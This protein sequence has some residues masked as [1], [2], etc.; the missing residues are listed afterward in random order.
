MR[1]LVERVTQLVL[2]WP[3]LA[4]FIGYCAVTAVLGRDVL[5]HLSSTIIHDGGDPLLTAALLRWN[6]SVLPLTHAWW[7]F[8][9]FYPTPDAL[10]FSEHLLGLSVVA[11]PIEW[12]LRDPLAAANLVTLLTYPLSGLAVLLL[13]RHLSGSLV[14]A[15]LA[16]LAFAFSPY[17]AG[18]LAH[19]QMLAV[20]WAPVALLALH[21]YLDSGRRWWLAIYGGAWLL[22][23]LANLYSMYFFSALVGLWVLWFVIAARRWT[24]LRNITIVTIVAA[25][26]LAPILG[27]YLAAHGRHGFDPAHPEHHLEEQH[28]S[29]VEAGEDRVLPERHLEQ[30]AER[31]VQRRHRRH[32]ADG[33]HQRDAGVCAGQRLDE[34]VGRPVPAGDEQPGL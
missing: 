7:Q 2:R 6:A 12:T 34:R 13:V 19:V 31:H 23:A 5:T 11:T 8:P 3:L 26:P 33:R 25:I 1:N 10:A 30:L 9:I 15:F 17:R 14:A 27:M 18:Q 24:A 22:Q 32:V 21:A 16:G 29:P 4:S 28:L 20:F